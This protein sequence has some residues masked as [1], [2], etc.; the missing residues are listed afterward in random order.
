MYY[1][2]DYLYL[3]LNY[4]LTY[5]TLLW[6]WPM[7]NLMDSGFVNCFHSNCCTKVMLDTHVVCTCLQSVKLH[8]K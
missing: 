3:V 4:T 6:P 8:M 7:N 2:Q 5:Y 1:D